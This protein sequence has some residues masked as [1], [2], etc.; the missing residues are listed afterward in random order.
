MY[1]V[2]E[3]HRFITK[4]KLIPESLDFELNRAIDLITYDR[5]NIAFAGSFLRKSLYY[6]SDIDITEEFPKKWS[7]KKVAEALQNIV[8]KL[9]RYHNHFHI[10]D[11]KCGYNTNFSNYFNMNNLGYIKGE[12]VVDFNKHQIDNDL[13]TLI[14]RHVIVLDEDEYSHLFELVLT[15]QNNL[16]N[17]FELREIIR[18]A[19]TLRWTPQEILDGEKDNIL[20]SDAVNTFI[21][22]IDIAFIYQG[23][24]TEMSNILISK[25]GTKNGL[26]FYPF[27]AQPQHYEDAI[28][29]NLLEY[30]VD[31]NYLK[32][33]KRVFT[34]ALMNDDKK[35]L[36]KI[37]PLLVSDV[38]RLNKVASILTTHSDML[39]KL[40]PPP[41]SII[42]F[43]I[44]SLK[45]YLANIYM[46]PFGEKNIDKMIDKITR[47][48]SIVNMIKE[49]DI[50]IDKIKKVISD[51][52]E[53][54]I[55]DN[56]LSIPK[57]Y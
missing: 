41:V 24:Y 15:A 48:K 17:W 1:T 31:E 2:P 54:Y 57:K 9:L 30:V 46:F 55:Y 13:Q 52:T 49:I 51:Q 5:N 23:Y 7:G 11:I 37:A 56:D 18:K 29:Y 21:T 38:S 28:K 19:I 34:L 6:S 47:S 42:K 33:L 36:K 39:M 12:K 4:K 20:L 27:S 44:D 32:A 53:I 14:D 35:L 8:R 3:F 50:I 10:L 26:I 16:K 45:S 25:E 40:D 43:Q 22:K